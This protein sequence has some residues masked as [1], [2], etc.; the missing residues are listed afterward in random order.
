MVTADAEDVIVSVCW[1]CGAHTDVMPCPE[2]QPVA[3]AE[4]Q[5]KL[6]LDEATTKSA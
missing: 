6:R 5:R 1:E 3:F 4:Y 2:D